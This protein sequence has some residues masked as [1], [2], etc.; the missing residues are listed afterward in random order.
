MEKVR[1]TNDY[2]D[3]TTTIYDGDY[4]YECISDVC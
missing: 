2:D 3:V 4:D 1:T